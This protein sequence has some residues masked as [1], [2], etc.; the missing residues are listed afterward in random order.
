MKV[1][2]HCTWLSLSPTSGT[3]IGN[4]DKVAVF[5]NT[6]TSRATNNPKTV[7]VSLTMNQ[8]SPPTENPPTLHVVAIYVSPKWGM[9]GLRVSS[10]A[11]VIIFDS[12][13][14]KASDA[15]VHGH[16]AGAITDKVS[17]TTDSQGT[18]IFNSNIVWR[19]NQKV[20]TFTVDYVIKSGCTYNLDANVKTTESLIFY[21]HKLFDILFRSRAN[22]QSKYKQIL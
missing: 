18:V 4:K 13:D 21:P 16:W 11:R 6:S 22:L 19:I 2:S 17:G 9:L 20:F 14:E 10:E 7:P 5:I 12:Q 8:P 1:D 15:I 3:S